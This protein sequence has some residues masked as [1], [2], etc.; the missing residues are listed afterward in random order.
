MGNWH[1]KEGKKKESSKN[2]ISTWKE[3]LQNNSQYRERQRKSEELF[4][5]KGTCQLNVTDEPR[6][7]PALGNKENYRDN[8][9]N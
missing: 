2:I 1:R 4:P 6:L 8:W 5:M 7:G 3:S 9:Q